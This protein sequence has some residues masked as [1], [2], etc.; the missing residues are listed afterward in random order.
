M[1]ADSSVPWWLLCFQAFLPP[2]WAL[3]HLGFPKK[4]PGLPRVCA[5]PLDDLVPDLLFVL[6]KHATYWV[7]CDAGAWYHRLI[8]HSLQADSRYHTSRYLGHCLWQHARL[9]GLLP[10]LVLPGA[11]DLASAL[12]ML[13]WWFLV[14]QGELWYVR[15]AV[16]LHVGSLLSARLLVLPNAHRNSKAMQ[17]QGRLQRRHQ[18]QEQREQMNIINDKIR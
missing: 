5:S 7:S 11:P 6:A 9:M 10:P 13:P 15:Y 17:E 8:S 18:P 16:R 4:A 12:G 2:L 3:L 1:L 14:W